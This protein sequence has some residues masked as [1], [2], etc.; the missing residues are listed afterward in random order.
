MLRAS[1]PACP[2]RNVSAGSDVAAEVLGAHPGEA[3]SAD[4]RRDPLPRGGGSARVGQRGEAYRLDV[5]QAAAVPRDRT[6]FRAH[7]FSD[8]MAFHFRDATDILLCAW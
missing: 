5:V 1:L 8:Q 4:P 2:E 7:L 6:N 3:Q